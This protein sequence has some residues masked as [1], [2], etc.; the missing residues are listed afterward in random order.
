MTA[1]ANGPERWLLGPEDRDQLAGRV[2]AVVLDSQLSEFNSHESGVR[3]GDDPEDLHAYRVAL[4]RA[5]SLFAAGVG[6]Y[7]PEELE[8][9]DALVVRFARQTST[10][11][12]LDVLLEEFD[13]RVEGIA[14][15][16]RDGAVDLAAE[17]R[18]DRQLSQRALV[19]EIDGELHSTLLRRWQ[20][21][22]TVYRLGGS[23]PGSDSMRPSGQVIDE[24]IRRAMHQLRS[25]GRKAAGSDEVARWH[26]VRKR[27][28]RLRYLLA[29]FGPLYGDGAFEDTLRQMR[30]LQN[31]LG[32]LQD[33]V[34]QV[35]LIADAGAAAGGRAGLTA[36]AL[37]ESAHREGSGEIDRCEAMWAEFDRPRTWRRIRSRLDG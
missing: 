37:C 18:A 26:K 17:L 15:E 28:K 14:P 1:S 4:R 13:D 11:R 20:T 35:T 32:E 21:M 19:A 5:R 2:F 6:V 34:A 30:K 29:I 33:G 22:G 27:L 10:L 31:R 16:L 36:G 7:P 3:A 9:L 23:E 12:D 8:L 25:A 24:A